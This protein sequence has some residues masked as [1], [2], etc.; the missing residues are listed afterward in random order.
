MRALLEEIHD[1]DERSAYILMDK[2]NPVPQPGFI[3]P[4]GATSTKPVQIVNELGIFG[5]FVRYTIL[6]ILNQTVEPL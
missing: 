2:V 5:V 3:L 1:S 4:P 6:Y